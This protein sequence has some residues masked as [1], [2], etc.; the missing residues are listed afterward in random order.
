M[1]H[2]VDHTATIADVE[3]LRSSRSRPVVVSLMTA[4]ALTI[5]LLCAWPA[6]AAV[7]LEYFIGL[8]TFDEVLLE[9]ATVSEF[10]LS[11]FEVYCKTEAEPAT[12][13]HPI[14][15]LVA[16]GGPNQG[17]LYN[18]QVLALEPGESYCFRITEI[19]TD[20]AP[21]ESFDRCGYGLGVTPTPEPNPLAPAGITSNSPLLSPTPTFTPVALATAAGLSGVVAPDIPGATPTPLTI[22]PAPT[23]PTPVVNS[24]FQSPLTTLDGSGPT[25]GQVLAAQNP[26]TQDVA[27]AT[28][29]PF[30]ESPFAAPSP[31]FEPDIDEPGVGGPDIDA[32]DMDVL[33]SNVVSPTP[34]G[35]SATDSV[36]NGDM[37]LDAGAANPLYLVV[38]ATPTSDLQ[39]LLQ[40][41][42]TP[43]PTTTPSPGTLLADLTTVSTENLLLA[44]FCFV[45]LGAS[46]I[47]ILGI[48]SLGL[49]LRSRARPT[50]GQS[51]SRR[52]RF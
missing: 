46:G 5:F 14:G 31:T 23:T 28:P 48:T 36:E 39:V 3:T 19:T 34:F 24:P 13:Y 29:T 25:D 38:T 32:Q 4:L 51:G 16:N 43:L 27:P 8:T 49:Y 10:N 11:G 45:F 44:T 26:L 17:W 12:A 1:T 33:T 35:G 15:T 52:A 47:G 40:P 21:G 50:G 41:T 9:W 20:G 6:R 37:A 22:Q 18:F 2:S 42:F 7:Q 30:A